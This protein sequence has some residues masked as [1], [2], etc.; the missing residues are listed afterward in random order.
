MTSSSDPQDIVVT[1]PPAQSATTDD[2][3]PKLEE[4]A[5]KATLQYS[6]K[7]YSS[8]TDLYAQASELQA[9][10]NGED[11]YKNADLLFLYGRSL[12]QVGV[13]KSDV[14]GTKVAGG[15][16]ADGAGN[17]KEAES[18]T[19]GNSSKVEQA[20]ASKA[21]AEGTE[22]KDR[23]G[24]SK[25]ESGPPNKPFFQITGD[26]NFDDTD[27]EEGD[28]GAEGG[29]VATEEEDDLKAAWDILDLSRVLFVRWWGEVQDEDKGKSTEEPEDVRHIKERLADTH[30]LLAEIS[31]ESE[32]FQSAVADFR[33]ALRLKEELY[34]ED[35][36]VL[37][38]AHFKLSLALEFAATTASG[39]NGEEEPK[40]DESGREEAAKEMEAAIACCRLR[41]QREEAELVA[42][43]AEG[44]EGGHVRK[45]RVTRRSIDDVKEM[46]AEMEQRL[47]DLRASP[48]PFSATLADIG[49]HDGSGTLGSVL[50]S[51]LGE[52]PIEQ[53][54]RLEEASKN[55]KDISG[56]VR[57]KKHV[58]VPNE[59][60]KAENGVN[61][62][63]KRKVELV[64]AEGSSKKARV[65]D[66]SD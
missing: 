66:A 52:S 32:S 55:A 25:A 46:I 63:G 58:S 33:T 53:K 2:R 22:A 29:D 65:E 19:A 9:E 35:S 40:V 24:S 30:D 34:P 51:I 45:T 12:Y 38:E 15:G 3:E 42:G 14:L 61:G 28:E 41:V 64:E 48:V 13:S 62:N 57:R 37:A 7:N 27:D 56:L 16:S 11:S 59:M 60:G 39:E 26:E 50:G 17:A 21:I 5:A 18:S 4:L 31:L 8:A 20:V 23:A 49:V 44:V 1:V 36:S 47:T 10:I 43:G 6:L 54:A